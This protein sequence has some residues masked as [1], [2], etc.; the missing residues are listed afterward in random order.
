MASSIK[1]EVHKCLLYLCT[2]NV[3]NARHTGDLEFIPEGDT[4]SYTVVRI[5]Q[6]N[7]HN[8]VSTVPGT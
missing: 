4:T 7:P 3:L 8:A 6:V 5:Q 1:S 2:L